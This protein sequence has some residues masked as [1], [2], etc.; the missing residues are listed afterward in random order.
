M[1]RP[2]HAHC[3]QCFY[4]RPY[5]FTYQKNAEK[6]EENKHKIIDYSFGQSQIL[7]NFAKKEHSSL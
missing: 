3:T 5:V 6:S 4:G 1:A 7:K 2:A